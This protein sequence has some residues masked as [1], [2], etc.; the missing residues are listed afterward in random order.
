MSKN[1][2]II[3]PNFWP[4]DTAIGL[5]NTQFSK[6]LTDNQYKVTVITA[7]PY[8]PQWS[9][10]KAYQSQPYLL[11][12][13]NSGVRILRSRQYIP[14][15]PTFF[16]RILH[17][18]SFTFGSAINLFKTSRPD[19]VISIVPF[20]TTILLGSLLKLYY[21]SKLWAHIQDF[22]FDAANQTGYGLK[23]KLLF[24]GLYWIEKKLLNQADVASTISQ[25]MIKILEQKT[26]TTPFFFPN[27]IYENII[28]PDS[29]NQHQFL[30]SNKTKILYSGNIG[31]KQDWDIF[32]NFCRD[33]DPT[34]YQIVVVGDGAKK[35]WLI[36]QISLYDHVEYY[37]PVSFTELSDLLCSTDFH[38]LFQKTDVIDTVMPSKILGMMA[39]GRPS[40]IIGNEKSE[41]KKTMGDS[42]GGLYFSNYSKA[43]INKIEQLTTNS[44]KRLQMGDSARNYVISNFSSQEIFE[45]VLDK[46]KTLQ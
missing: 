24:K 40:I 4:E 31:Q 6:F 32:L 41:V 37:P 16:K 21:G 28:K 42:K 17:L 12:E 34:Q 45:K 30:K 36:D 5:Y 44:S 18:L 26:K 25:S 29:Y 14:S 23:S 2:T 9:I 13:I 1:I 46:L 19:I 27:W 33:I 15:N 3:S 8:Y 20:T 10:Y 43:I 35:K 11:E 39:S 7:F 38:I 22:E